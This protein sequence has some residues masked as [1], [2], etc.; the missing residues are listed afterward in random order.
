MNFT[1]NNGIIQKIKDRMNKKP[2]LIIGEI[3]GALENIDILDFLRKQ[4]NV[5]VIFIELESKWD[6]YFKYSNKKSFNREMRGKLFSSRESWLIES[7]LI[8]EECFAFW[9]SLLQ[10]GCRIICA[11]IEH[12]DWNI[13]EQRTA[14][15]I[16]KIIKKMEKNLNKERFIIVF[17]KLHARK[18]KFSINYKNKILN[19]KPMGYLLREYSASLQIR[20]GLGEIYNFDTKKVDDKKAIKLLGKHN[21]ILRKNRGKYFDYDLIVRKARPVKP[22]LK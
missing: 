14:D 17:G 13:A 7:G 6:K 4:L 12:R 11:K 22:L 1:N 21:M 15:N 16:L 5:K 8:G 2:I 10:E 9:Q 20:Y 3:H 19:L 18:N